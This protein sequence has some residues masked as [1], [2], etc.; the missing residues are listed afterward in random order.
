[1]NKSIQNLE[2]YQLK[3]FGRKSSM[4]K[5]DLE[6]NN[7]LI[8]KAL[9]NA[10][11]LVIGG[12]GTIGSATCIELIKFNLKALHVVDISENNLVE[13]VRDI[14]S[15]QTNYKGDLKTLAIDYGSVEFEVFLNSEQPYEFVL[16][17][18]AL[19]HVRGERDPFTLMRMINVNILNVINLISILDI[20]NV[21]N[22]FT[23]ST[24]KAANPVNLMG[25]SKKIM[26][27][28]V[29]NK[30]TSLS[31]SLARF[32]NVGFSDGSLLYGFENRFN[33]MQ[34]IAAP[35]DVRRFFVT[36]SEAGRFCLLSAILGENRNI[37][38]PKESSNL[39]LLNFSDIAKEIIRSKGFE[40]MECYS[41]EE[42]KV[43]A[44]K[45]IS[46]KKWP[47][48]FFSSDTTGEKPFE[49]FFTKNEKINFTK[50]KEI[51]VID[52]KVEEVKLLN[53][54]IREIKI[55]KNNKKWT[56][57]DL[58]KIFKNTLPELE[59]NDL[60]RYLDQRM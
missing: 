28:S 15:Q 35:N 50:Y 22:F 32:A 16:N 3:L 11:V 57:S 4:F 30:S 45:V 2:E 8:S 24:D 48:Y 42:A 6:I 49:E 37:F 19:K 40:P 23:V 41:E 29:L 44:I 5:E 51:G 18:S 55:L 20:E 38:F 14:R 58:V 59:Y 31:V 53:E 56:K 9:K 27:M 25:A 52:G 21:N 17:L 13:L 60:N 1:M 10:R 36:K 12:A 46:E 7:D 33:K 47:C 26:E 54:F 39:N 34:P 43:C